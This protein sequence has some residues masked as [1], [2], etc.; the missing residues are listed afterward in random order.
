MIIGNTRTLVSFAAEFYLTSWDDSPPC[1]CSDIV[2]YHVTCP[3]PTTDSNLIWIYWEHRSIHSRLE[4]FGSGLEELPEC[5]CSWL[6]TVN[7]KSFKGIN[8]LASSSDTTEDIDEATV[9]AAAG[10]SSF[11]FHMGDPFPDVL[12]ETIFVYGSKLLWI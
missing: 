8:L 5:S 11:D 10:A 1:T 9:V 4:L 2:Q 6:K 12:T 3:L 7:A